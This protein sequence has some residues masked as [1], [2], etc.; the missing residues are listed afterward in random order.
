[1]LSSPACAE[2]DVDKFPDINVLLDLITKA[3]TA[4]LLVLGV[5]AH[6]CIMCVCLWA[7]PVSMDLL[8]QHQNVQFA[9]F[10]RMYQQEHLPS[11]GVSYASNFHAG[12]FHDANCYRVQLDCIRMAARRHVTYI[13]S[14]EWIDSVNYMKGR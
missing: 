13:H 1:M 5:S 9:L 10:V 7:C 14:C 11:A 2:G 6:T 3:C 8:N 4:E 12:D